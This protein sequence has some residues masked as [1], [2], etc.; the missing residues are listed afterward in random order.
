MEYIIPKNMVEPMHAIKNI[1]NFNR[2][3]LYDVID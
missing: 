3:I 1:I 2:F